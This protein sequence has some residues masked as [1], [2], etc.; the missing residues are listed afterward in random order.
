MPIK[1]FADRR[2][3]DFAAGKRVREFQAFERQAAKV[4]TKLNAA[5]RLIELRNPQRCQA[6]TDSALLLAQKLFKTPNDR[7]NYLNAVGD[8]FP[9]THCLLV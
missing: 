4:L 7:F 6:D 9:A 2:T 3:A 1:T 5:A 8:K